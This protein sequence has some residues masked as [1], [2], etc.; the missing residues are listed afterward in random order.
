[1]TGYEVKIVETS[2]ELSAKERIQLKDTT[3]AIKLDKATQ[4]DSVEID[5]DYY[6]ELSIHNDK[7]D[8]KDYANY[9]IVDKSGD[10]YVT[11]SPSFWSAF[12]NIFDEMATESEPWKLKVYR[13]PSKNREGKDFI[14]CSLI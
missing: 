2:K 9:V 8:D 4:V 1:M 13:M 12:R 14:T 6:A 7:A 10:R 3:D 5:V 11:G